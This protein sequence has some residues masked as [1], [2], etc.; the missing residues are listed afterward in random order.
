[1]PGVTRC[2]KIWRRIEKGNGK[3]GARTKENDRGKG[4]EPRARARKVRTKK[5]T[6][7]PGPLFPGRDQPQAVHVILV[8][9]T[10]NSDDFLAAA[11]DDPV[12]ARFAVA[13]ISR[14]VG[15]AG[16]KAIATLLHE[17]DFESVAPDSAFSLDRSDG[18]ALLGDDGLH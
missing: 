16:I 2:F 18:V 6:A 3:S 15:G 1:E 13:K 14:L 7:V 17:H 8:G 10:V 4:Y 9:P 11:I 12:A 5:L